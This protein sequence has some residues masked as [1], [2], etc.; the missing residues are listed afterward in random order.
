[1]KDKKKLVIGIGELLW[2]VLPTGKK[3]G[4]APCNFAFHAQQ[5][6]CKSSVVSALGNDELGNEILEV[7]EGLNLDDTFIQKSD[8]FPTG[9]VSVELDAN[10]SP[11]YTIHENVA[12]DK[13]AWDK[14]L[15]NLA[16]EADAV[17]F[18]TLAQRD[19]ISQ[20]TIWEFL[21]N[22]KPY[23]L[24]VFDI[25]LRQS[26]YKK[27]TIVKSL[28]LA[29]VLK[30]NDE[31][32]PI[33]A[34]YLGYKGTS[35]ENLK[36]LMNEFQLKLIAYTKGSK[37]SILFTPTDSSQYNVPKISVVD[38]VGAGDSFTGILIAG[39]LQNIEIKKIHEK[40]TEVSAFVCTQKGATPIVPEQIL[41]FS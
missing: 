21:E 34:D 19:E 4:G 7:L 31:E 8:D 15:K 27:E 26:F 35:D 20:Q 11:S 12:W 41:A 9:T 17:C 33:V 36:K 30:L 18:G 28:E 23:C 25:N 2:D 3:L 39:L 29:N 32:L 10:G 38:T 24:R 1:M 40:A 13:I 5:A 37:G 6:G 14:E 22:T 16:T